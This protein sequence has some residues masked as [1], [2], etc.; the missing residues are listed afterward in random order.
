V[1]VGFFL[2]EYTAYE[3]MLYMFKRFVPIPTS[4]D[5][6]HNFQITTDHLREE[7]LEKGLRVVVTSNPCNPTGRVIEGDELKKWIE[8]CKTTQTSLIMDEFYSHYI[9][10]HPEDENG[11]TVSTAEYIDDV[12][13]DPVIIL[14]GL[15]KNWRCPGWRVC[16]ILGPKP[17]IN[18]LKSAGSFLEGGANHPLQC[19]A[20]P[21]LDVA[22]TKLEAK[23]LQDH[24]RKKRDFVVDRLQKIGITCFTPEATFYI[25]ANLSALPPP[26]DNGL[27]F[28][29]MALTVK[30]IVVPGIFFDVNPGKRRELFHSPYHH[31]IRISF[32][33]PMEV[34]E[35]GMNFLENLVKK[36]RETTAAHTTH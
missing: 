21:L 32:G 28:F 12:D 25:W 3:E 2:P 29:E 10:T 34:L 23:H 11:R 24:F 18:T 9:Y 14:D 22:R 13:H 17:L 16:W 31:Y 27:T 5:V 19:A 4:R 20:I 35:R 15:T 36:Q 30:V 26:L 6:S 33:P 1:N 7:I 8:I